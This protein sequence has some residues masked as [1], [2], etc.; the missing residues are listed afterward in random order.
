MLSPMLDGKD[1]IRE[2]SRVLD[3]LSKANTEFLSIPDENEREK[4]ML[5]A[6][7]ALNP[8]SLS[9]EVVGIALKAS[10]M[11]LIVRS[12]PLFASIV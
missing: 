8:Q 5:E 9:V 7:S 11:N 10:V 3:F 6:I 4:I 2:L 1:D 12:S